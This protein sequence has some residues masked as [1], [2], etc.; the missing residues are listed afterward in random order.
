M[1]ET[2]AVPRFAVDFDEAAL[3]GY[4]SAFPG[5]VEVEVGQRVELHDA[6]GNVCQGVVADIGKQVVRFV[7]E[8]PDRWERRVSLA[9]LDPLDAMRALLRTPPLDG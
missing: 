4:V 1:S 6:E 2:V 9:P 3:D 8:L 7:P 5:S